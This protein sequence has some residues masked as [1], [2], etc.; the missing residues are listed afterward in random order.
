M[1]RA[2][3]D[4]ALWIV[5]G[6]RHAPVMPNWGGSPEARRIFPAVI[7]DFLRQ[8]EGGGGASAVERGRY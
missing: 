1:Y 8:P 4:A 7:E 2:I 5:P 6:E 3:P